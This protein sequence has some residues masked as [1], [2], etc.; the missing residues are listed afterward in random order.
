MFESKDAK[1][2]ELTKLIVVRSGASREAGACSR[3]SHVSRLPR[4]RLWEQK[5]CMGCG[6]AAGDVGNKD[7]KPPMFAPEPRTGWWYFFWPRH[8]GRRCLQRRPAARHAHLQVELSRWMGAEVIRACLYDKLRDAQKEEID[9]LMADAP[10]GRPQVRA[11]RRW[12]RGLWLAAGA[13]GSCGRSLAAHV[14]Y[15]RAVCLLIAAAA[16]YWPCTECSRARCPLL[17]PQPE[18]LTRKEAAKLAAKQAAAAESSVVGVDGGA[19]GVPAGG[20]GGSG[21]AGAADDQVGGVGW[22]RS[23]MVAEWPH[24]WAAVVAAQERHAPQHNTP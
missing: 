24:S 11:L 17:H 12:G 20:G 1:A 10:P 6:R 23:L 13:D 16:A 4:E 21:A 18:R 15:V 5:R 7:A 22:D 19:E 9:R 3:Q 14:S 2:R 8:N